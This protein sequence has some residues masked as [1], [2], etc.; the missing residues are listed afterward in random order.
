MRALVSCLLTLG[1]R[2]YFGAGN[3]KICRTLL[4]R[5]RN[6]D[7]AWQLTVCRYG[8]HSVP[9]PRSIATWSVIVSSRL[10]VV[11]IF[12]VNKR[13]LQDRISCAEYRSYLVD[14]SVKH[15]YRRSIRMP[16][17]LFHG[18]NRSRPV[19]HMTSKVQLPYIGY[20]GYHL[21]AQVSFGNVLTRGSHVVCSLT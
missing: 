1:S 11:R 9:S 4:T 12:H 3:P 18:T 6:I 17:N 8:N 7:T 16:R 5:P 19:V 10:P 2:R 15:Q 21:S 13:V 20:N 14:F